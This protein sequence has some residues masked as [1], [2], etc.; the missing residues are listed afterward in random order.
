MSISESQDLNT[1]GLT[2]NHLNMLMVELAR[3]LFIK[4]NTLLYGGDLKYDKGDKFN[5]MK[6]LVEILK[7]YNNDYNDKQRISNYAVKPFSNFLDI[8]IA[9]QYRDVIDFKSI[10][11]KCELSDTHI[12]TK[13][14][15]KMREILTE[16]MDIKIA[17]GG[18]VTG[19]SG[20]YIGVL[21]EI[22]L[23]IKSGKP[24]YLIGGFGGV[25]KKIIDLINGKEDEKLRFEYQKIHTEKLRN[26]L[27]S[28]SHYEDEIKAKYDEM[29][30]FFKDIDIKK[31]KNIKIC[32]SSSI[33]EIVA[34]VLEGKN[35]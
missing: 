25:T 21:E 10:G 27:E 29:Y 30:S 22:Y 31:S 13:N 20:F 23:A 6:I 9:N 7:S 32:E 2:I 26:F 33:D 4:E 3:Y 24:T 15:T 28:N 17:I 1:L 16:D 35:K 11:E 19:F 5:F 8:T 18:K 34:F 12:I 14:L